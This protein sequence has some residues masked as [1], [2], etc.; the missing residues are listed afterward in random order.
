SKAEQMQEWADKFDEWDKERL[1]LLWVRNN[2]KVTSEAEGMA[3][4]AVRVENEGD[5]ARAKEEWKKLDAS[6]RNSSGET[7][8]WW[9]V[10]QKRLGDLELVESSEK[11]RRKKIEDARKQ[12][13][14]FQGEGEPEKLAVAAL[15]LELDKKPAEAAKQWKELKLKY[16]KDRDRHGFKERPW[17]V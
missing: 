10:A 8:S 6:T 1:L 14:T 13:Q 17:Y 3:R 5:L 7:R 11:D 12:E 16:Q 4:E 15:T 9:L 2:V